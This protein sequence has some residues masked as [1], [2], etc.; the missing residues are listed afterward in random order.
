MRPVA[1]H[2]FFARRC[3]RLGE[4]SGSHMLPDI[5]ERAARD[6]T[7]NN[8]A[9]GQCRGILFH[10]CLAGQRIHA[11]TGAVDTCLVVAW[12]C[13]GTRGQDY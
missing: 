12:A 8:D 3:R 13:G 4:P 2:G 10:P 6:H 5:E 7:P 11:C 9:A 1:G